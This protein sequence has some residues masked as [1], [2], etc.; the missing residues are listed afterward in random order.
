MPASLTTTTRWP[1]SSRARTSATA[2]ASVWSFTTSRTS[3]ARC[4]GGRAAG[5]V[6][7]VSSQATASAPASSSTAAGERSPRLPIGVPTQHQRAGH[8]SSSSIADADAPRPRTRPASPR[9]RP[10]PARSGSPIRFGA[11]VVHRCRI[12][13]SGVDVGDVDREAHP[14]GVHRAGRSQ[15]HGP[16]DAV[17]AEQAP[18]A[19]PVRRRRPRGS[20]APGRRAPAT[21]AAGSTVRA[22]ATCYG[23]RPGRARRVRR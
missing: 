14:E 13:N 4:R 15:Q 22:W 3:A 20:P 16:V 17:A 9:S 7:R 19:S 12:L 21:G 18:P 1:R 10:S 8:R 11:I 5:P 23:R 2:P 6:R